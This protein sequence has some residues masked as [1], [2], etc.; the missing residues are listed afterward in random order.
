MASAAAICV[1]KNL[2]FTDLRKTVLKVIWQSHK[3]SKAYDILDELAKSG[4]SSKPPTVYRALDFLMD[5]GLI[6]KINSLNAFIGC[7]HPHQKHSCHFIICKSCE[8]ISECCND[9]IAQA[10]YNIT[11]YYQFKP[12]KASME[13][14]GICF[15]CQSNA[16][17]MAS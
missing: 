15:T 9:E 4:F 3:P 5:L 11:N 13:I 7:S 14:E 16:Q 17:N 12:T 10:I 2:N 6:H 8:N 1:E